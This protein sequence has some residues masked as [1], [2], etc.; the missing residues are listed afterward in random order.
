MSGR[1]AR[2]RFRYRPS[3][4]GRAVAYAIVIVG[5]VVWLLTGVEHRAVPAWTLLLATGAYFLVAFLEKFTF[6]D[7]TPSGD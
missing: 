2:L 4:P 6:E 3:K 7:D 5:F 1:L